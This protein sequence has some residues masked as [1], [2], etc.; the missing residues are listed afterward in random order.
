MLGGASRLQF[1]Q[2]AAFRR[3]RTISKAAP[4]RSSSRPS[5]ARI[6]FKVRRCAREIG[7]HNRQ[8]ERL[9]VTPPDVALAEPRR[10][11][12]NFA[13]DRWLAAECF[14]RAAH[15][16]RA[17]LAFSFSYLSYDAKSRLIEL[18]GVSRSKQRHPKGENDVQASY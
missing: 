6:D 10:V 12:N 2:T 11:W 8:G 15:S 1:L 3:R 18:R 9:F 14:K 13:V 17:H 7:L 5:V 4:K 16:A